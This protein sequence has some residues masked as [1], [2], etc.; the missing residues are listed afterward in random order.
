MTP[1]HHKCCLR[2][3]SRGRYLSVETFPYSLLAGWFM[4]SLSPEVRKQENRLID[5]AISPKI[6]LDKHS[7][8][9]L[10][11][12]IYYTLKEVP[13]N[14]GCF[15]LK[16]AAKGMHFFN[17]CHFFLI[18]NQKHRSQGLET[19][20]YKLETISACLQNNEDLFGGTEVDLN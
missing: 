15:I 14:H 11:S 20:V 9:H 1:L 12:R 19:V 4:Q 13:E 7:L 10:E 8:G 5:I 6:L 2:T 16:Y 17:L 18:D 3:E